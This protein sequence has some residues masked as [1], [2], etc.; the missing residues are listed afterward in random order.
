MV[1][2]F[3]I[4]TVLTIISMVIAS[5]LNVLNDGFKNSLT[6]LYQIIPLLIV[7]MILAGMLQAIIPKEYISRVLGKETGVKGIVLGALIGIIMP[8]G[9]YVSFPLVAVIYRGGAS[10]GSVSALLSAWGLI[11]L[12]RFIN[13]ELPI[14]G[15]HFAFARYLSA[16]IFP[17]II[18]FITELLFGR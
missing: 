14:L 16:M 9:P 7:A 11:G 5:R 1:I 2:P 8:G 15:V 12:F 18:G 6:M 10:I 4:I 13:F 17:V 3:F